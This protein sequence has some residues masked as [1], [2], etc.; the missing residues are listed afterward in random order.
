MSGNFIE[1]SADIGFIPIEAG[2][3]AFLLVIDNFNHVVKVTVLKNTK[4]DEVRRGFLRLYGKDSFPF[5]VFLRVSGED[6]RI[7]GSTLDLED[8]YGQFFR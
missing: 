3:I 4:A 8:R 5:Q 2:R 7:F 1:A 6:Y